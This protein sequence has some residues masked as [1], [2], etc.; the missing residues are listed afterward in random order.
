MLRSYKARDTLS[1]PLPHLDRR[2]NI[3]KN[4]DH[5]TTLLFHY[6]SVHI[7]AALT[8]YADGKV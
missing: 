8:I 6:S 5:N 1:T 3:E 7:D 4:T 2:Y